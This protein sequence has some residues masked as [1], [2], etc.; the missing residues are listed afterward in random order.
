MQFGCI[1]E[2]LLL[3]PLTDVGVALIDCFFLNAGDYFQMS[4]EDRGHEKEFDG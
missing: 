3:D 4:E 2:T 1:I